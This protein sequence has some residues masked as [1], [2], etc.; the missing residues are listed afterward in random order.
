MLSIDQ[1]TTIARSIISH[2]EMIIG[3]LAQAQAKKIDGI[4]VSVDG[5]VTIESKNIIRLLENLVGSY[6]HIFGQASVEACKDAVKE[7]Q[8][9]LSP[10]DLPEIL[11]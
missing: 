10:S 6:Q 4:H 8:L 1:A 2:Q 5:S 3:P 7:T 9:P 11:R